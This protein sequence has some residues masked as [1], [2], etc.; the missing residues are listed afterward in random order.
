[1]AYSIIG[2][3]AFLEGTIGGGVTDSVNVSSIENPGTG[4]YVITLA[5]P[6]PQARGIVDFRFDRGDANAFGVFTDTDQITILV[7]SASNNSLVNIPDGT[8]YS[9]TA[10][11]A[12]SV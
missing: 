7:R 4:S 12:I 11:W 5:T 10:V 8:P 3:A 2:P 6:G 1:M 9:M